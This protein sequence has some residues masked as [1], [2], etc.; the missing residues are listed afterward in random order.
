M[1]AATGAFAKPV[2]SMLPTVHLVQTSSH[3]CFL[4][5][6]ANC[7]CL[8]LAIIF[9]LPRYQVQVCLDANFLMMLLLRQMYKRIGKCKFL[10]LPLLQALARV[11]AFLARKSIVISNGTYLHINKYHK[12]FT[13]CVS[14]LDNNT[15]FT[16]SAAKSHLLTS[17]VFCKDKI[18]GCRHHQ[19]SY[20]A[21][22]IFC[23]RVTLNLF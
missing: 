1:F 17:W 11:Y 19:V 7:P 3:P 4:A 20:I 23:Y 10:L 15:E 22:S 13:R 8:M 2:F 14:G 18:Y 5:H 12:I 9:H 21:L 16:Y 6:A